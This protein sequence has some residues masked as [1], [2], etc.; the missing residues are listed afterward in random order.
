VTNFRWDF[1]FARDLALTLYGAENVVSVIINEEADQTNE[2]TTSPKAPD[3][4]TQRIKSLRD[5]AKRYR[6]MAQQEQARQKIKNANQTLT[7]INR[8]PNTPTSR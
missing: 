2:S 3:P 4:A 5:Q 7:K 6:E 8:E 1:A